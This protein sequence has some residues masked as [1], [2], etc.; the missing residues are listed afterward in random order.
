MT[1]SSMLLARLNKAFCNNYSTSSSVLANPRTA[2]RALPVCSVLVTRWVVTLL[3]GLQLYHGMHVADNSVHAPAHLGVTISPTTLYTMPYSIAFVDLDFAFT[4]CVEMTL[5]ES[6]YHAEY[7]PCTKAQELHNS[8]RSSA[9]SQA[10]VS[11]A[12]FLLYMDGGVDKAYSEVMFP[13]IRHRVFQAHTMHTM[14]PEQLS[15]VLMQCQTCSGSSS[16]QCVNS[17]G[18]GKMSAGE[19]AN[20][21]CW[22]LYNRHTHHS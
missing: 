1:N 9:K 20:Q 22:L 7:F 16:L 17:C 4:R 2:R 3:L 21:L 18:Y 11:P 14:P 5:S 6:G 12:D 13:S 19:A 8:D 15:S 10:Y